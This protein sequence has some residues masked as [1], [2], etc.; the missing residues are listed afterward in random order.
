VL[1]L[2]VTGCDN[3]AIAQTLFISASTVVRA[4]VV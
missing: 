3:Q 1:R 2:L 4:G